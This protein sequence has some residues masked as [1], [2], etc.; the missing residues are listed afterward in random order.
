MRFGSDSYFDH[1]YLGCIC[2]A[3]YLYV[4]SA[5]A[6]SCVG[7]GRFSCYFTL[8]ELQSVFMLRQILMV[9]TLCWVFCVAILVMF[10]SAIFALLHICMYFQQWQFLVLLYVLV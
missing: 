9:Y 10:T 6:V 1:I 2:I 4:F 8:V 3:A 7:G 5:V